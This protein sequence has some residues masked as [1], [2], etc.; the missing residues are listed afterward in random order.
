MGTNT[1][2]DTRLI[3]HT[4]LGL[5]RFG[6]SVSHVMSFSPWHTVISHTADQTQTP[7]KVTSE[8]IQQNV[9]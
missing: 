1:H 9:S 4:P 2:A 3:F 7:F 6:L 5:L 8:Q